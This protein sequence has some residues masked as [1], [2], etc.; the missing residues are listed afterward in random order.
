MV[1]IKYDYECTSVLSA[2][3]PRPPDGRV[4]TDSVSSRYI[5]GTL[6]TNSFAAV[7]VPTS[8]EFFKTFAQVR[9]DGSPTGNTPHSTLCSPV[10]NYVIL[11]TISCFIS[12]LKE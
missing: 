12:S 8:G 6:C 5:I 4:N 10:K 7:A 11:P 9:V 3:L 2:R 1:V